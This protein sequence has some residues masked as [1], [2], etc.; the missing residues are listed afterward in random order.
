M[1]DLNI[2]MAVSKVYSDFFFFFLDKV[3]IHCNRDVA[4][5][6]LCRQT[7]LGPD[8]GGVWTQLL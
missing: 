4:P 2:N 3:Q 8:A 6:S 5:K 7:L 1:R